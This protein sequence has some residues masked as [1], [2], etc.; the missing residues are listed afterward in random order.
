MSVRQCR[1]RDEWRQCPP[2][3]VAGLLWWDNEIIV[4]GDIPVDSDSADSFITDPELSRSVGQM[5]CRKSEVLK[6]LPGRALTFPTFITFLGEALHNRDDA[7]AFRRLWG[8]AYEPR[9]TYLTP[10]RQRLL[11]LKGDKDM[12]NIGM[13]FYDIQ[14]WKWRLLLDRVMLRVLAWRGEDGL[15]LVTEKAE[16]DLLT[17]RKVQIWVDRKIIETKSDVM[18]LGVKLYD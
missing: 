4:D 9:L 11:T 6:V 7:A 14:E 13:T 10:I 15:A 17:R 2:I 16:I 5:Q 3:C 1:M 12:W 18:Y 8:S